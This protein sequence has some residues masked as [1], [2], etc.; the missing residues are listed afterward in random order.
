ML[1]LDT[2]AIPKGLDLQS[3]RFM[4]S[5]TLTSY[6]QALFRTIFRHFAMYTL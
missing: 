3:S 6:I 1:V 2:L 5:L 4:I